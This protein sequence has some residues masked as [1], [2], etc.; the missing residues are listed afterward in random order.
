MEEI[1]ESRMHRLG[2]RDP[3]EINEAIR[4]EY[5]IIRMQRAPARREEEYREL[6][7]SQGRRQRE[8]QEQ[9]QEMRERE[10]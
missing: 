3:E 10:E 5:E 8:L 1:V 9:L 6:R 2:I 4:K 7:R